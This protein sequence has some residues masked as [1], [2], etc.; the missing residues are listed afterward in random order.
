[1]QWWEDYR[2][3][4]D[5]GHAVAPVTQ[6]GFIRTFSAAELGALYQSNLDDYK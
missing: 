5:E 1:M 2:I 4:L 3:Q 6:D